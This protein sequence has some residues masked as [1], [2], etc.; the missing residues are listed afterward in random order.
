MKNRKFTHQFVIIFF[1]FFL[2]SGFRMQAQVT[3]GL[4][5]EPVHGALLQ[6]KDI[7]NVSDGKENSTRGFMLPRVNL[8]GISDAKIG[9]TTDFTAN[10]QEYIGLIVYNLYDNKLTEADESKQLYKGIYVWDGDKWQRL[11]M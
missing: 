11:L 2:L 3:I 4:G 10:K 7:P 1:L 8:V 9:T 6:I 5:E